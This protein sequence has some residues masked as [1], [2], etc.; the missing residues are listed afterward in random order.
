MFKKTKVLKENNK[1]L[2]KQNSRLGEIN[3]EHQKRIKVLEADMA[4]Q[5]D[6]ITERDETINK[7]DETIN[8]LKKEIKNLK[9]KLTMAKKENK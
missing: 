7:Q 2:M 6:M 5:A 9:R 1:L 8:E 3:V 4:V